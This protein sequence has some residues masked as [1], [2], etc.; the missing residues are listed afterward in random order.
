MSTDTATQ[1]DAAPGRNLGAIAVRVL[2]PAL[3]FVVLIG[4]WFG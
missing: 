3:T 1:V 2:L 4:A